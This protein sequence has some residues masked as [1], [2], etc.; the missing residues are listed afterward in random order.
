LSTRK[1]NWAVGFYWF[2]LA[3]TMVC[4][5]LIVAGNTEPD[6]RLPHAAFP[7]SWAFA[8]LAILAFLATELFHHASVRDNPPV[9]KAVLKV[10]PSQDVAPGV[11]TQQVRP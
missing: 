6:W 5:F 1:Q 11:I 8:G 10:E 4:V 3:M 7:L 9:P 2:G